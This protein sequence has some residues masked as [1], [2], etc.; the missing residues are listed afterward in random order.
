VAIAYETKSSRVRLTTFVTHMT[1]IFQ[2]LDGTFFGLFKNRGQ[3][4][5][6][7]NT[8]HRTAHFIAR[9]YHDFRETMIGMN[10]LGALPQIGLTFL[11][12]DNIVR[13]PFDAVRLRES[14]E[15]QELWEIN[16]PPENLS[17][18]GAMPSL[19]G[20]TKGS[21]TIYSG[22]FFNLTSEKSRYSHSTKT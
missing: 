21:Q 16:Y 4:Q 17:A 19:D 18:T 14:P 15:L 7:F 9:A 13:I 3:Y 6:R 11:M 8:D 10:I 2:V 12:V 20:S 5:L 22:W 1:P